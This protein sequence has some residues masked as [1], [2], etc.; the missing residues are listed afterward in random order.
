MH[1]SVL[2]VF[3]CEERGRERWETGGK[4]VKTQPPLPT[5]VLET[6]F[7]VHD[8][9]SASEKCRQARYNLVRT[10]ERL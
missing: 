1:W 10:A 6:E 2:E 3:L 9:E 4:D 5:T 7:R 8:A